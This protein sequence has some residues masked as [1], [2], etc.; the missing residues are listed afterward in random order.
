MWYRR[1][2]VS[3]FA[4]GG[5]SGSSGSSLTMKLLCLL[6]HGAASASDRSRFL[7]ERARLKGLLVLPSLSFCL[8]LDFFSSFSFSFR[9]F[10]FSLRSFSLRFVSFSSLFSRSFRSLSLSF[11]L[12]LFSPSHSPPSVFPQ[13]RHRRQGAD[14]V[15]SLP[16]HPCERWPLVD[17]FDRRSLWSLCRRPPPLQQCCFHP[18]LRWWSPGHQGWQLTTRRRPIPP[19]H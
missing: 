14:A 13:F 9:S 10:S 7:G 2:F 3:S 6:R 19:H 17:A 5:A 1:N 8:P 11:S 15:L 18:L 16:L 12:S 4:R